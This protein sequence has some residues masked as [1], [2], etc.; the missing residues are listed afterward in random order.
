MSIPST[1]QNPPYVKPASPPPKKSSALP[2]VQFPPR[3]K[4]P[5]YA[6]YWT[7]FLVAGRLY[8]A[9]VYYHCVEMEKDSDPPKEILINEWFLSPAEVNAITRV[10]GSREH[11]YIL[12][13]ISHGETARRQMLLPQ[14]LLVGR[15][16]ELAKLLR[17]RGLSVLHQNKTLVR[18]YLDSRHRFFSANHPE[19]F[20]DCV[21]VTGW[22]NG[23]FVLP[24]EVIG[25]SL[26]VY[27]DPKGEVAK[28]GKAGT[29]HQWEEL[30]KLAI[31]NPF[32]I[33]GISTSLAGPLLK[34]LDLIGIGFHLL[35]DST[36]GKTTVLIV[37]GSAWGEPREFVKSWRTTLNALEGQ[38]A[39]RSDSLL[40]LDEIHLAE[41]KHLD[42]AIYVLAHGGSK[43]RMNRNSTLQESFQWRLPILSSGE[44][45]LETRLEAGGLASPAGQAVRFADIP[46]KSTYG[47][48]DD[49][50]GEVGGAE[51][52]EKLCQIAAHH[53]GH[54]GPAFIERL[55]E[56]LPKLSLRQKLAEIVSSYQ[57]PLSA[58]QRRVWKS[59]AVAA[60]AGELASQWKILPWVGNVALDAATKLFERWLANQPQIAASREHAQICKMI[61]DFIDTHLDSRFSDVEAMPSTD[62]WGKVIE[63]P[64]IRD[65][66]GYWQ[67]EAN[68]QRIILFTPSGLHEATRGYDWGRV[69]QALEEA[70]AFFKVGSTQKSVSRRI[71]GENNRVVSFYYVD[72]AKLRL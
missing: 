42:L 72:I 17:D 8:N 32:L 4:R 55:I 27:F 38:C 1:H 53:Y 62:R 68:G 54:I 28:Y 33:F 66:A 47:V 22:H 71:P 18:D 52:S 35:G 67:D 45:S 36:S 12:E 49:L 2:S 70:G 48:F 24:K 37:G 25:S 3:D 43:D 11:S 21:K 34:H 13:Y 26:R 16:D 56:E 6:N 41:A 23:V 60:L 14:S 31:G 51:F 58:Q 30:A 7:D 46:A 29:L 59:F 50:H 5:C 65:R 69:L 44:K 9:G 57:N 15:P 40:P 39:S 64:I 61:T 63:P 20:W 19:Y 10:D